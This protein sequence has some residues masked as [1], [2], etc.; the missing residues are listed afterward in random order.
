[1]LRHEG[2]GAEHPQLF[3][4]GEEQEN[5]MIEG[6]PGAKSPCGLEQRDDAGPIVTCPG[7]RRY[8]VVVGRKKQR[9]S[10]LSSGEVEG[11]VH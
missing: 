6:G 5:I 8:A 1:M 11:H 7:A 2:A 3:A 4:I 10:L 9:A